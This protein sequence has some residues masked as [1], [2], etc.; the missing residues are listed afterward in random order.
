M[1]L[2]R[3][4]LMKPCVFVDTVTYKQAQ[5][6]A[7]YRGELDLDVILSDASLLRTYGTR[8]PICEKNVG[9]AKYAFNSVSSEIT[10]TNSVSG[11]CNSLFKEY[12]C[13]F[14]SCLKL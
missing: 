4:P 10:L 7:R 14:S 1:D 13:K 3:D 8:L 6:V 11:E 9:Q 5:F 12:S 2:V